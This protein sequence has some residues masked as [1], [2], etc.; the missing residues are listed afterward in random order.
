MEADLDRARDLLDVVD[1]GTSASGPAVT[2]PAW[3]S[4]LKVFLKRERLDEWDWI[5]ASLCDY[6]PGPTLDALRNTSFLDL[7]RLYA[8]RALSN[9]AEAE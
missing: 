7:A 4:V 3:T 9:A 6:R 2:Y 5:A 1:Q 8:M